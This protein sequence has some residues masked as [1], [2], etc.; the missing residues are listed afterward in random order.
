M[1]VCLN[2]GTEYFAHLNSLAETIDK[3]RSGKGDYRTVIPPHCSKSGTITTVHFD[4]GPMKSG[5]CPK[6]GKADIYSHEGS[7]YAQE[8][9]AITDGVIFNK[10]TAPDKYICASCGYLEYY[11]VADESL[12]LIREKWQ[13]IRGS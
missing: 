6:C 4:G 13:K 1:V 12:Q 7:L 5:N 2:I 9:V 10:S 11:V 8:F 3:R